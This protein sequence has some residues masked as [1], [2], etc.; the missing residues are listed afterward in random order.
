MNFTGDE[1]H[2]ITLE[3]ASALTARYRATANAGDAKAEYFGKQSLISLLSQNACVGVRIYYGVDADNVKKLVLV[4][5][6]AEGNDLYE[7]DLMER[8]VLCPPIC[9]AD[10]PLNS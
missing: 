9:S 4:G 10:N 7:G 6:D 2:A 1:N 3:E 5:V 8:G